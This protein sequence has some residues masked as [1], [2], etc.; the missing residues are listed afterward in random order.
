VI[1][2]NLRNDPDG[3]QRGHFFLGEGKIGQ[4][5]VEMGDYSFHRLHIRDFPLIGPICGQKITV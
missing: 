1:G 3:D 4:D 5:R 2:I